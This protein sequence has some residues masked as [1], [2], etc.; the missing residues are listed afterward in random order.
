MG[1]FSLGRA[2]SLSRC[3]QADCRQ[4]RSCLGGRNDRDWRKA[5]GRS[6]LLREPAETIGRDAELEFV[7]DEHQRLWMM[8]EAACHVIGR[9]E[10]V[11]GEMRRFLG[12]VEGDGCG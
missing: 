8:W 5:D 2:T 7:V 10:P 11:C 3:C 4:L 9:R 6:F 12:K 1:V